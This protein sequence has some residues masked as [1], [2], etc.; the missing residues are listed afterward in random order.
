MDMD[1][2]DPEFDALIDEYV[3]NGGKSSLERLDDATRAEA[4]ALLRVAELVWEQGHGA[5]P[6]EA[7][8]IAGA[9]GLVPDPKTTLDAR[10]L[11]AAMA[12]AGLQASE[13]A[14]R[15]KARQWPIETRDVFVWTTKGGLDVPPALIRA[16]A[17]VVGTSEAGLTGERSPSSF[18]LAI[19]QVV[20]TPAFDSLAQRWAHLQRTTLSSART[21]LAARMPAAVHRGDR[22]STDQILAS[23]DALVTALESDNGHDQ[24]S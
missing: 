16:I 12:K 24:E 19:R 13:V 7:D 6:L 20:Q 5:P 14:R 10:A 15:L 3:R 8:P 18:E 2:N 21:A 9:L 11:K 17:K 22:P 1:R 4:E 23:L